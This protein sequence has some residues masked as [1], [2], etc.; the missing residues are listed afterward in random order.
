[1][2]Q[3]SPREGFLTLDRSKPGTAGATG[4]CF[5]VADALQLTP[6]SRCDNPGSGPQKTGAVEFAVTFASD[7]MLRSLLRAAID[8][9]PLNLVSADPCAM[10]S[11]EV[12]RGCGPVLGLTDVHCP[13]A[14]EPDVGASKAI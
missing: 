8:L 4:A 10:R 6:S 3:I 12:E 1:V 7:L 11:P 9:L 13:C 5:C 14:V 2:D